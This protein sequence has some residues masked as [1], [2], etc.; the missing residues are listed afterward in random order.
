MIFRLLFQVCHH[1]VIVALE[2]Q[3][4]EYF[5]RLDWLNFLLLNLRLALT[6]LV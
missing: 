6:H 4:P 3:E 2:E 1:F 5:G